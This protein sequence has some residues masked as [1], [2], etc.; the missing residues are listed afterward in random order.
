M[1]AGVCSAGLMTTAL[2]AASSRRQLPCRHQDREVP[3]DDLRHDPERLV[4]VVR[5]R[6]VVD[7]A[8]RTL[9]RPDRPR[10]VAE[11]VDGERDVGG[12]GLA[13]RLAVLPALRDRERLQVRLHPVGD[14]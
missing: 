12:E 6:V 4:E 3:R 10:E 9:L 14:L 5:H 2:P 1:D 13:D 11:V 8:Q 7:L